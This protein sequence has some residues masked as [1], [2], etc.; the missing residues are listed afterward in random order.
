MAAREVLEL[1]TEDGKYSYLVRYSL[2]TAF[3]ILK[4]NLGT[5]MYDRNSA[6]LSRL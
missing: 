1:V 4:F 2:L 6:Q 5:V 3:R